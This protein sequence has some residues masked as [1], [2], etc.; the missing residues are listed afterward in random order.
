MLRFPMIHPPLPRLP[1]TNAPSPPLRSRFFV[2]PRTVSHFGPHCLQSFTH[3]SALTR[4]GGGIPSLLTPAPCPSP[5]SR[6]QGGIC[7]SL[8]P[9][10]SLLA[11]LTESS[12]LHS[13]QPLCLPLLRKL[14]GV[15]FFQLGKSPFFSVTSP[16]RSPFFHPF[17]ALFSR[18]TRHQR[19]PFWNAPASFP[20]TPSKSS[21]E[22][23]LVQTGSA[24]EERA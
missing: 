18:K 14:P 5:S 21:V 10:S 7:F 17:F 6:P 15:K 20:A 12:I 23:G 3:S 4:Q 13:P 11:T 19:F 2:A 24:L 16:R 8:T 22:W 1:G 9:L